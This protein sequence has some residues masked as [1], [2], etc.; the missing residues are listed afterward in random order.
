MD[1]IYVFLPILNYLLLYHFLHVFIIVLLL[2]FMLPSQLIWATIFFFTIIFSG[3]VL[4]VI[5]SI[6]L[7]SFMATY[8]FIL[9]IIF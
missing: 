9:I 7:L 2:A 4:V 6:I 1:Y 8:L 3:S 5:F